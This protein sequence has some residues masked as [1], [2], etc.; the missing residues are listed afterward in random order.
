MCN[1]LLPTGV[2]TTAVKYISYQKMFERKK[3]TKE[4]KERIGRKREKKPIKIIM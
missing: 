1:V 3:R 2:N 4:R